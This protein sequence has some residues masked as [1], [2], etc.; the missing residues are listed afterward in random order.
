LSKPL[1]I[2]VANKCWN[3]W[4][5]RIPVMRALLEAGYAVRVLAPADETLPKLV[6]ALHVEVDHLE[7]FQRNDTSPIGFARAMAELAAKY[8]LYRPVLVL[9]FGVQANTAGALAAW[10]AG[11]QAVQ[12]VTGLGYTFLHGGVRNRIVQALQVLSARRAKLVVLENA[13]DRDL[14]VARKMVRRWQTAVVSGCGIDIAQYTPTDIPGGRRIVFAYFGRLLY[15]KGLREFYEAARLVRAEG[16]NAAFYLYGPLDR[17]NPAHVRP[18]ELLQWIKSGIVRYRGAVTDVRPHMQAADVVVLPSYREGLSK[19]LLEAMATARPVIATDVPGCREAVDHMESG[20]LVP[21]A[22][23]AALAEAMLYIC[24][25]PANTR[26]AMGAAGRR[27]AQ[28]AFSGDAVGAQ[29]MDI[30]RPLLP[31]L[32]VHENTHFAQI[33]NKIT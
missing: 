3:I 2:L 21:P 7:H 32:T 23:T 6:A 20:L 19:T 5:Y 31:A 13:A 24:S 29:Y 8:R 27:K 4:N 25:L 28:G 30:L 16:I 10:M 18:A 12:V 22:D 9:H 17:Q 11:V 26:R 1:V 15:D 33:K 14:M